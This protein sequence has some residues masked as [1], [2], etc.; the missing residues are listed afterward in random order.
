MAG[1]AESQQKQTSNK[2]ESQ[3]A[4]T[5]SN[6][7]NTQKDPSKEIDSL[8]N[9]LQGDLNSIDTNAALEAIDEWHKLL[10]KTK[11]PDVKELA[12]G[13]K[14]LKQLLKGGK[15]SGHD[16]GEALIH[17]GE[18]TIELSSDTD[19][20]L[21][22]SVQKLGKQLTKA[23]NSFCKAEDQEHIEQINTLVDTLDE[24]LESI[25]L[26]S[27]IS[28]IDEWYGVLHKS[29]DKG[30]S[31]IADS[32]KQLKKSLKSNKGKSS[33]IARL[34]AQ[35]GE[36]TIEAATE[37]PRGIKGSVQRLGKRLAKVSK[38]IEPSQS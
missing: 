2:K 29:E 36:Q 30:A 18:Q 8:L 22:A 34:L 21:K 6:N 26:D 27:A 5:Q 14:E 17:V 23:G 28:A 24:D 7:E 33:D 13:L 12:S 1:K 38:A 4:K 37:A 11:D 9:I 19:K 15:A 16:I 31:Q 35:L 3:T 25:E 10:Q 20:E 32:L